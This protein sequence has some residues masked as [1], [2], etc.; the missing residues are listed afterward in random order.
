MKSILPFLLLAACGGKAHTPPETAARETTHVETPRDATPKPVSQNVAIGADILRACNIEFSNPTEAPK[1]AYDDTKLEDDDMRVLG[2]VATCLTS[3][4]LAGRSLELVGRADPRGSDQYNMALG[5]HRAD[6]VLE[7]LKQHGVARVKETSRGA[8]DA[9]GHD[10]S[11]WQKDR[12]VD[13]VL[14][15]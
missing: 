11:G 13:L 7:F 15:S 1:F 3:G 8:I 14:G 12:R 2:K 10:E 4:P 9:T 6:Q 5:E